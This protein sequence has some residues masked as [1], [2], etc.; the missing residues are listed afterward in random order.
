MS[1]GPFTV[2]FVQGEAVWTVAVEPGTSLLQAAHLC[3]APVQTLCNGVGT[4]VLCKVKVS[5]EEWDHLSPPTALERNRL[6][7]IFHL[8]HERM[9]CQAKAVAHVE[10]EV[11]DTSLPRRRRFERR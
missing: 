11:V 7:N 4:C 2:R 9:G 6:G 10:V 5:P 3:E 8:L 1:D